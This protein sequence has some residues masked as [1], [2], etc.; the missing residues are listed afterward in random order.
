MQV[1]CV[2][3]H[4]ISLEVELHVAPKYFGDD[5]LLVVRMVVGD[6]VAVNEGRAGFLL[7]G[8]DVFLDLVVLASVPELLK[9][10]EVR[11]PKFIYPE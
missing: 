8:L 2:R 10:S 3:V 4:A 11:H 1:F 9:I 5:E 6:P 7:A